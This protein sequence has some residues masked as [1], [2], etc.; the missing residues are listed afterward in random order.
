MIEV[1]QRSFVIFDFS[2]NKQ[3]SPSELKDLPLIFFFRLKKKHIIGE[4]PNSDSSWRP[5][6]MG[7]TTINLP[8]IISIKKE[9][10]NYLR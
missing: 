10:M 1:L 8:R 7:F 3:Q 6:R 2:L 9:L 5:D 4:V